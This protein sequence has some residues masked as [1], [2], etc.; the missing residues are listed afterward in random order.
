M[1]IVTSTPAQ[2]TEEPAEPAAPTL[3]ATKQDVAGDDDADGVPFTAA[4]LEHFEREN[5]FVSEEHAGPEM[6]P[7]LFNISAGMMY[8]A[9]I[10]AEVP[11]R[12]EFVT[13]P[14][15]PARLGNEDS[16]SEWLALHQWNWLWESAQFRRRHF[17]ED[18]LPSYMAKIADKG[19]LNVVFVP[20]TASRYEEYAPLYHLIPRRTLERFGLPLLRGAQYPYSPASLVSERFLPEDFAPRL[21]RAWAHTVWKHLMPASGLRSFAPDEPIR[22]LAHNLDYWVPPVV[23]VIEDTLR[24]FPL[25][26]EHIEPVPAR[27][28]DETGLEGAV[29]GSPRK[30]GE[31]WQGEEQAAWALEDIIDVAD[32]HGQLR[33]ILDAVRSNRVA[34]DFSSHWS[35]AKE[36]FER[37]LHSKRSKVKV[38]FVELTDT[39]PV[40]GPE[41]QVVG[42]L[43]TGDFMALLDPRD[44]Q[45]VV[46]LR[47]GMT[48]LTDIAAELGYANHGAVSKRLARIRSQAKAFFDD[49]D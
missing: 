16:T 34:D 8:R 4:E 10:R 15:T 40:Q 26:G 17:D 38:T 33:G 37:K 24:G 6:F 2:P 44:R 27:L 32:E 14:M 7:R 1:S 19:D 22:L 48:S 36:D 3:P 12:P 31:I 41:T 39:I 23:Q 9:V 45:V 42:S 35:Y 49:L 47:S 30:G 13:V 29:T 5:T 25:G 18:E 28:I 21:E 46:L 20:R 43:V 11:T